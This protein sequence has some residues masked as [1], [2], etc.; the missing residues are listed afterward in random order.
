M[1]V[2]YEKLVEG[3]RRRLVNHRQSRKLNLNQAA[4]LSGFSRTGLERMENGNVQPSLESLQ[5]LA[6]FYGESLSTFLRAA[7]EAQGLAKEERAKLFEKE[8]KRQEHDILFLEL[9]VTL[10]LS[11]WLDELRLLSVLDASDPETGDALRRLIHIVAMK[12][13]GGP[14][15]T[16]A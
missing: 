9:A 11:E 3:I 15:K 2:H 14:Q 5:R 13:P 1:S 6:G 10:G 4:Q 7:E 16:N 8:T 12:R